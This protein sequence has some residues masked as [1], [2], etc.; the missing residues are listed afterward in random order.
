MQIDHREHNC[1]PKGTLEGFFTKKGINFQTTNL[2][3][4]DYV[5]LARRKILKGDGCEQ[6]LTQP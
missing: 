1:V 3:L 2:V 6:A 4:G 5:W